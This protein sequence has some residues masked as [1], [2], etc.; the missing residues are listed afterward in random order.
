M[1][2]SLDERINEVQRLTQNQ[3]DMVNQL[4]N[5]NHDI[6]RKVEEIENLRTEN[7]QLKSKLRDEKE[8]IE[9]MNK[10]KEIIRIFDEQMQAQRIPHDTTRLGYIDFILSTKQ[11]ESSKHGE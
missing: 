8:I 3:L 4:L 1:V 11:G 2:T 7:N 5:F 10:P 6:T 9:R